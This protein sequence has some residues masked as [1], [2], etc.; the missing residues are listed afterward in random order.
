MVFSIVATALCRICEQLP[1]LGRS[2]PIGLAAAQYGNAQL[3]ADHEHDAS[4]KRASGSG[5]VSVRRGLNAN[6][7]LLRRRRL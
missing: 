4:I 5:T 2:M 1:Q 6:F 3:L 7:A